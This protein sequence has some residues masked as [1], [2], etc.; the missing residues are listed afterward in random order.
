MAG[1]S[2][3]KNI[4]HRKGAQDAKRAKIFTKILRE[5]TVAARMG[6]V[7][8]NT[9][10]R[11]RA[12]LIHARSSNVP[13]D[14][15]ERAITK[16]QDQA[17]AEDSLRYEAFGP[18]GSALLIE[19]LSANR[20]KSASEIRAVLNRH[21]ARLADVAFMFAHESRL[22]YHTKSPDDLME[23]AVMHGAREFVQEGEETCILS[24]ARENFAQ[25]CDALEP[26]FGVPDQAFLGWFAPIPHIIDDTARQA[27]TKLISAL[28]DLDDVQHVWTNVTLESKEDHEHGD[29][30]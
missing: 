13:K 11:L 14:N 3:F 25:L 26:R 27:L 19:V 28:E 10:A 22:V 6:G 4:M 17:V 23:A 15:L 18:E 30:P 16:S 24:C 8:P 29:S 21:G 7:D 5:V 20:N 2:Q 1:H 12:I 9:N